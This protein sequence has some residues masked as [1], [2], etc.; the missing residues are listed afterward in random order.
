MAL[1]KK[2]IMPN[3]ISLEYHR[4]AL[5]NTEPNQRTTILVHSY[6]DETA[7]QFEKDYQAGLIE[8]TDIQFPYAHAE[9]YPADYDG[10]M[11]IARAYDWLLTNIPAF[12]DAENI[13]DE[14]Q[15]DDITGDEFISMLEEVL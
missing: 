3:G 4:V 1:K 11:S 15:A 8:G 10:A 2:V 7:R 9:Y 12:K 6:F 14:E 13:L 5:I